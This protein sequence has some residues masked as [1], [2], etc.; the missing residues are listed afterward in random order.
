M[1]F[2]HGVDLRSGVTVT[3]LEGDEHGRVR[4]AHLSDGS[5]VDT[6][7]VVAALGSR[8]NVE[9]L[10]DSG[11]AADRRGVAC[12]AACR[13]FDHEGVLLDDVF[14]AG[15]V[16]RWPHRLYENQLLEVEHWSNAVE[17]AKTAAHNMICDPRDRRAHTALPAFWSHQFGVM[18]KSVGVPSYADEITLTQGRLDERRFIVAYGRGGRLVAAVSFNY[19][20]RLPT[21]QAMI[22]ASAPFPPDLNAPDGPATKIIFPAGFP[23]PGQTTHSSVA[24]V[25]GNRLSDASSSAKAA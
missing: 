21:Y 18:I 20:M 4:R 5:V 19:S 15:D 12:D 13:A 17:Q 22:E 1:Y 9:W 7:L 25:T 23:E 16:A 14:V 11:L 24:R 2:Q 3:T 6:R 10:A 8:R